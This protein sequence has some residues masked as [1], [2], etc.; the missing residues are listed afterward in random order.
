M[1]TFPVDMSL[2]LAHTHTQEYARVLEPRPLEEETSH[3]CEES[4]ASHASHPE[5]FFH[6]CVHYITYVYIK[7]NVYIVP[8]VCFLVQYTKEPYKRDYILQKRPIK[9]TIFCKRDLHA[10]MHRTQRFS[11]IHVCTI[12]HVYTRMT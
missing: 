1:V 3:V 4:K 12:V 11:F 10:R 6:S 2:S 9:E 5:V 7:H 8:G